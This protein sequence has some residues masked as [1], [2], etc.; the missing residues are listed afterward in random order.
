MQHEATKPDSCSVP[1]STP[2]T[3]PLRFEKQTLARC[4]LH[5]LNKA[6]AGET[7]ASGHGIALLEV[8]DMTQA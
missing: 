6:L 1:D 4:G 3:Y 8:Q 5:A 7:D 2:T